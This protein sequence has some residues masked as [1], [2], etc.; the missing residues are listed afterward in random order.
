MSASELHI[1][2]DNSHCKDF[3]RASLSA[4]RPELGS[5]KHVLGNGEQDSGWGHLSSCFTYWWNRML[6]C[7]H[8]PRLCLIVSR[9]VSMSFPPMSTVPDV[10]GNRPV[11]M[12]LPKTV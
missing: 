4:P 6:C 7:G 10:G 12:D 2:R 9:L 1:W 11:R 3:G 5:S 8:M